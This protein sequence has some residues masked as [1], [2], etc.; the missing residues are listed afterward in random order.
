MAFTPEKLN[1]VYDRTSGY[2]HICHKKL[3]FKNYGLFG[4]HGAWE[5]EHSNPIAKG[6]TNGRNNL[7]PACIRCNRSKG[8]SSTRSARAKNG[9]ARAP[10]SVERRKEVKIQNTL[11]GS[12][13][14]AA[15]G[16]IFGRS[17]TLFGALV[18]ARL[19]NRSNPDR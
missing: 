16:S 3:A 13:A 11:L 2:C 17:G 15:V 14:G 8:T 7:Y 10:L 9:K 4:S 19:G 5:V 12:V 1:D 6:G 18:G